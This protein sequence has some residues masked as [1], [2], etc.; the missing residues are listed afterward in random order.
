MV[1]CVKAFIS[2]V[3]LTNQVL[4]SFSDFRGSEERDVDVFK[5]YFGNMADSVHA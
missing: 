1:Y 3:C 5:T 2:L 4:S